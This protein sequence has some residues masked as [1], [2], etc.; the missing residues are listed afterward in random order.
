MRR[1]TP[2]LEPPGAVKEAGSVPQQQ[3]LHRVFLLR[4]DSNAQLH[5]ESLWPRYVTFPATS[6]LTAS[7]LHILCISSVVNNLTLIW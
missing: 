5:Q 7:P 2:E 6:C 3:E 4:D 1:T